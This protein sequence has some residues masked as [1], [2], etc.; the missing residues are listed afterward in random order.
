M[1]T[2][3]I[4]RLIPRPFYYWL[5][6][7]YYKKQLYQYNRYNK[8]RVLH[9]SS[10]FVEDKNSRLANL[11][12]L[13]HVLEKGITMPNRRLGFGQERVRVI[14][15]ECSTII[16]QW[17]ADSVEVQAT[18]AD[19]KQYLEI[20][21]ESNYY[22]PKDISAGIEELITK[23]TIFDE[24]CYTVTKDH[25]F[26]SLSNFKEFAYS[27]HSVRWYAENPVDEATLM[28]A[29]KLAQTAPSACNRQATRVK[30]ISS[31]EGKAICCSLQ[32]GNRGFG[33]GADKWLLITTEMGDWSPN[34]VHAGY[35][36]A[37]IFTMNLL[38]ALHYYGLVAC[39]LNAHLS[40]YDRE[41]LRRGLGYPESEEPVVFIVCGNPTDE[42]MV[43][44]SRRLPVKSIIQKC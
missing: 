24:N 38:Y 43:P 14:I 44:K 20:H 30:I 8:K 39:T 5:K 12:V 19:L 31:A 3:N 2:K 1:N 9:F 37:G 11:M 17:G 26:I 6:K 15:K 27:R 41:K 7:M 21:Q 22:L 29:V 35:I 18:L 32:N 16:K 13:S 28:A 33:E 25:Y 42:F 4:R 34:Q 23:M 10:P 40:P 36:D